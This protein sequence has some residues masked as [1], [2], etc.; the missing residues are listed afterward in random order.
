MT[1]NIGFVGGHLEFSTICTRPAA[2]PILT[3]AMLTSPLH[4]RLPL[5]GEHRSTRTR[6]IVARLYGSEA[7]QVRGDWQEYASR[8][9]AG[10]VPTGD[11]SQGAPG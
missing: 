8:N 5:A 3:P 2:D 9:C 7:H 4:W 11:G 10:R 6:S 1:V